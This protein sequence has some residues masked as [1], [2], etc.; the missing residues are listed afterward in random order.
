MKLDRLANS[1]RNIIWGLMGRI[2]TTMLPFALRT[3]IQI[4]IGEEYLG[5][6]G[7]FTSMLS[8]LN[9]AELGLG[10]AM[11]YYMYKPFAEDNKKEICALRLGYR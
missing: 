3:V 9:L 11:I 4:T 6:S 10:S 8:M 1:K 7:L 5:L 2:I